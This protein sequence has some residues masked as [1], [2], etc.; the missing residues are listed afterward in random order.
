MCVKDCSV[1]KMLIV[2]LLFPSLC[3]AISQ[4]IELN[5]ISNPPSTV[6]Y[7]DVVRIPVE[8]R[9]NYPV[10]SEQWLL[11]EGSSLEYVGGDCLHSLNPVFNSHYTCYLDILISGSSFRTIGGALNYR[12]W[13]VPGSPPLDYYSPTFSVQVIPHPLSMSTIPIQEATANTAFSYNLKSTVNYYDENLM[14]G[15]P[16]QG[17]VTPSEQDG[18]RF[19]E[20]SFSIIGTPTRTGTYIFNIGA[21]NAYGSAS[22]TTLTINVSANPKDRPVFKKDYPIPTAIPKQIY[23]LN[24]LHLIELQSSFRVTNQISFRILQN[25]SSPDWLTISKENGTYLE[26]T[27][28]HDSAGTEVELTLVASSNT[29]GDSMPL[30]IRI[31]IASD[32]TKKPVLEYFELRHSVGE[33]FYEDLSEY[34]KDPAH[35]SDVELIP[36]KIEPAVT[37]I[38]T[39]KD[40]PLSLEGRIPND[41][42][43]QIFNITLRASTTIGGSS[44]PVT[45]PL[46]IDID[47]D[48]IPGFR[49]TRPELPIL[50]SGQPYFYDFVENNDIYPEFNTT[51][52]VIKFAEDYDPPS[53]I[54]LEHNKL[55]A[56]MVPD[57]IESLIELKIL[58]SNVPGGESKPITLTFINNGLSGDKLYKPISCWNQIVEILGCIMTQIFTGNGLGLYDSS[59]ANV[60]RLRRCTPKVSLC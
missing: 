39:S 22:P 52:Y 54:T 47:E 28:P 11:P 2:L 31:P 40:R 12:V 14:A 41:V 27:A 43:G 44:E 15:T 49:G 33:L 24:L 26:G 3:F 16:A 60:A 35:T 1:K 42:T 25:Q 51:P 34:I 56:E 9:W 55:I 20:A 48:Q 10:V 21:Q 45:V 23:R 6:Y 8:M 5:F 18:L 30:T 7:G 37:W 58:I 36:D 46:K 29:G 19:D 59:L 50:Y 4:L 13:N 57:G 32:P 17:V 53:W 38:K